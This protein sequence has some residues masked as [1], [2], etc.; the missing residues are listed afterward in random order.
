M[1]EEVILAK[2]GNKEA[3]QKLIL[4]NKVGMY[5]AAICILKNDEDSKDAMQ[6]SI[7]QAYENI[8]KLKNNI[9]FKTWLMRILIHECYKMIHQNRKVISFPG[10]YQE[11][12]YDTYPSDVSH[13]SKMIYSLPEEFRMVIILFYYN[14]LPI[15]DISEL[16]K[17]PEGTV[18]SRLN[19]AKEHLRKMSEE[20][21]GC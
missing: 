2:K 12:S 5:K 13:I 6:N 15:K 19:R 1:E 4:A 21:E 14:D 20:S 8:G 9:Y 10:D 18:K 16:L 17:I 7:I 11:S 3:F